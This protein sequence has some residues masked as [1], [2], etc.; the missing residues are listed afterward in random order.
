M[1]YIDDIEQLVSSTKLVLKS[2]VSGELNYDSLKQRLTE[3]EQDL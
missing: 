2:L 1:K 3:I